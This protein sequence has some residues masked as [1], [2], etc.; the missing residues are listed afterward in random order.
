MASSFASQAPIT[1]V[2][3]I[4]RIGL[5]TE[6]LLKW[7]LLQ[8][9]DWIAAEAPEIKDLEIGT[10]AYAS[11][12]HCDM[13]RLLQD[14]QARRTWLNEISAR[15]MRVSALNV[16][17][18][19]L[20]PDKAIAAAHDTA[21]RDTIKLAADLGINRV[22][23]MA[24]C[25]AGAPGDVMPHFAAGGWLPYLEGAYE[26]QWEEDV[27]PYWREIDAF[28][29]RTHPDLLICLELH[30]GTV[31]YNVESFESLCALGTSLA[32]NIDPS[33]FFWMRMDADSVIRRLGNRIGHAHGK[34]VVFNKELLALNG[35][36]DRRWPTPPQQM[37]WNFAVVGRGHDQDW[38][39][40]FVRSLSAV[41][42]AQT[43]AIEHEDP[44]V[45]AEVG[46]KSAAKVIAAALERLKMEGLST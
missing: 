36:L 16:W 26:R 14:G 34:D 20:H 22:V 42:R 2:G 21:L 23:A 37:P 27:R 1:G 44:F 7:P 15:D 17:G 8:V 11:P 35:L 41:G 29:Q 13:S 32:A 31:V 28:V 19:P 38:W 46:I 3:N 5:V 30:P 10:G 43:I 18:N 39:S 33:H 25:P 45:P 9:I 6:A 4:P 12:N 24:G 40:H